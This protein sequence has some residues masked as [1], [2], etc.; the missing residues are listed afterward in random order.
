MGAKDNAFI[1]SVNWILKWIGIT[2]GSLIVLALVGTGVVL[3]WNWFTYDRYAAKIT[4]VANNDVPS[5]GLFDDLIPNKDATP[6]KETPTRCKA[7]AP[8][9]VA[10]VNNSTKTISKV[11]I[12]VTAH[13]PGHST[14]ILGYNPVTMDYIVKPTEG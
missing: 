7:E 2:F 9:F 6:I 14:N 10:I 3:A 4:V 1:Q 11:R 8:I 12:K 5:K 13:L